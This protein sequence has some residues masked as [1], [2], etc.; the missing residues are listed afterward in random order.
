MFYYGF[1]RY[2]LLF[3]CACILIFILTIAMPVA[4]W[5][6]TSV[7]PL[8]HPVYEWLHY[9]RVAG[10]ITAY[11]VELAPYSRADI[12]AFLKS[13][14]Q[15]DRPL[16]RFD[17]HTLRS[18][19]KE[20]DPELLY[21][22]SIRKSWNRREGFG[23]KLAGLWLDQPEPYLFR[24]SNPDRS[25]E[26]YLYYSRGRAEV[27]AWDNE[28]WRWARYY[29]NGINGF[30]NAGPHFGFHTYI[31]NVYALGDQ[32]LLRLDPEWGYSAAID[33]RVH[34]R[35]SY[36]YEVFSSF[37]HGMFNMDLGRGSLDFGPAV[38]DP[39][40]FRRE[41]PNFNWLRF[42]FGNEKL[43]LMYLH[44]SLQSYAS[45]SDIIVD[46]SPTR[47][48]TVPPRW[49]ALRRLTIEPLPQITLGLYEMVFYSN[50]QMDLMYVNPMVPWFF[51]ESDAGDKDRN[52]VGADLR[53]RPF[54]NSELFGSFVIDEMKSLGSVVRLE[55]AQVALNAG[56]YQNLPFSSQIGASY[57]RI[58]AFTYTHRFRLNV[59]EM[60]RHPLAHQMGPNAIEWAFKWTTWLP[61]RSRL[62][63]ELQFVKKGMDPVD[64][65]GNKIEYVGG[66]L[67]SD[68]IGVGKLFEGADIHRMTYY[69]FEVQTE[70]IRGLLLSAR[71]WDRKVIQGEQI[72]PFRYVDLRFGFGF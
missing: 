65:E 19:R 69:K 60:A 6:Q 34:Q 67:F 12:T 27:N 46:G 7:V 11:H 49:L 54:P 68:I 35:A 55:D 48:R 24:Y 29:V 71:F 42:S 39:L 36:S 22:A 40:V 5:S 32:Y 4:S 13:I 1:S 2:P 15:S 50:R 37:S 3:V 53:I 10:R 61:F 70:P 59:H 9:Q 45:T 62:I 72:Q 17:R 14:E 33:W 20:F 18:Y 16:N 57:T 47:T 58:D 41:A 43:N 31:D 23:S 25:L 52:M 66:D 38:S 8:T 64:S 44:G 56:F 26:T 28:A 30:I 21:D 63:A 51:S